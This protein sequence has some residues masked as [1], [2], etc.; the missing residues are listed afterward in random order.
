M[1]IMQQQLY[2]PG[3]LILPSLAHVNPPSLQREYLHKAG[4]RVLLWDKQRGLAPELAVPLM[5][6]VWLNTFVL[7][8]TFRAFF[9]SLKLYFHVSGGILQ[10]LLRTQL[11]CTHTLGLLSITLI[12]QTPAALCW[13]IPLPKASPRSELGCDPN[14]NSNP[15]GKSRN[16]SGVSTQVHF[17]MPD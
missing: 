12:P 8:T 5:R 15:P 11:S 6:A 9:C 3:F 2:S 7:K 17:H 16:S 4:F 14:S 1:V 10:L 13:G